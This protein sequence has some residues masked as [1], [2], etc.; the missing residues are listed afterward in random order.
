MRL[1]GFVGPKQAGKDTS[2]DFLKE[3]KKANGKIAFAG[4]LKQLCSEVF[5]IPANY[6]RQQELKEKELKEPV[7][8][9]KKVLRNIK[10][11]CSEI[12]PTVIDDYKIL[13]NPNKAS[14]IGLENRI[15]KT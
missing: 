14:I 9:D 6:F 11:R 12:V 1:V 13:Y 8:L 10:N 5:D 2:A 15:L 7:I 3:L 4:P